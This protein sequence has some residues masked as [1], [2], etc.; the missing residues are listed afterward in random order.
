[1]VDVLSSV[2]EG[3]PLPV[4]LSVAIAW[5]K[6]NPFANVEEIIVI[7]NK[8]IMRMFFIL[9]LSCDVKA[10]KLSFMQSRME[11]MIYAYNQLRILIH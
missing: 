2:V 3:V 5:E 11:D 9:I 8:A 7:A 6:N 4:E 10:L 1:M